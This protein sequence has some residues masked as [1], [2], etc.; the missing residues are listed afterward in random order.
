MSGRISGACLDFEGRMLAPDHFLGVPAPA[1]V[2]KGRRDPGECP[3]LYCI[4]V[5]PRSPRVDA[6]TKKAVWFFCR[7]GRGGFGYNTPP[8]GR[9]R[10][11]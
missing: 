11:I 10:V 4:I 3:Q 6:R 7:E 2:T 1:G 9:R 5:L 8:R